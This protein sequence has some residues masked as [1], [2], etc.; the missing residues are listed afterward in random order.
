M[1]RSPFWRRRIEEAAHFDVCRMNIWLN[2]VKKEFPS[3]HAK[4]ESFPSFGSSDGGPRR[5]PC[6][7]PEPETWHLARPEL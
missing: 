3:K 7:S 2:A 6:A 1:E 5:R 4:R